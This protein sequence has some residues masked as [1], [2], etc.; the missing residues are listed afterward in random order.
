MLLSNQNMPDLSRY[1]RSDEQVRAIFEYVFSMYQ[2]I[3]F[4]LQ[5]LDEENFGKKLKKTLDEIKTS[6]N[7]EQKK[8]KLLTFSDV[9][10]IGS[11]YM[12]VNKT[13]PA[14]LFGGTWEQITDTFLLA[15]GD[16]YKA[17][18]KGGEA[19]HK[20]TESEMPKHNHVM[21]YSTDGRETWTSLSTGKDGNSA[22]RDHYGGM[23]PTVTLFAEYASRIGYTGGSKAHNNMPPYL[24]VYVW[25]RIA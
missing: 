7:S 16:T 15:A 5:N 2:E 4:V 19:T 25:K 12:S 20:L 8:E 9:Y 6:N 22:S 18:S 24:T 10:P 14:N 1:K 13:S 3:N 11:L 17:G 23:S 21:E